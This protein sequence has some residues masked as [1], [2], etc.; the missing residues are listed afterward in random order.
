MT[1]TVAVFRIV[2]VVTTL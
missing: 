2:A 1:I